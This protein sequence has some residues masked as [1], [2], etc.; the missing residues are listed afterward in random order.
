MYY[1][2]EPIESSFEDKLDRTNFC[3]TFARSIFDLKQ[4]DTFTIGL[5]GKWGAG[6]TSLVNMMLSELKKI[7]EE[8]NSGSIII[9]F[10]PWHFTDSTHLISQFLIK[11]AEEFKDS[12]KEKMKDLFQA[13]IQYASSFDWGS[14]I[15]IPF[16]NTAVSGLQKIAFNYLKKRIERNNA[17]QQDV[18]TQK[19]IVV[20][21]LKKQNK[22][23][24]VIIDDIERLSNE[25]IRQVFQLVASIAKFP[26]TIYLLA[27]DKDI[28]VK[29]LEKFQEGDG[30]DYLEK[31]VQLPLQIPEL[32]NEK[33]YDL[34]LERLDALLKKYPNITIKEER[35]A[36]LFNVCIA[37]FISTIR[38]VNRLINL[39][40]FKFS[41]IPSDVEFSDMVALSSIEINQPIIYDWIKNNKNIVLGEFNYSSY[42]GKKASDERYKEYYD[43]LY[44]LLNP[45][46]EKIESIN[47]LVT[48]TLQRVSVLFPPFGSKIGLY[49]ESINMDEA[50]KYNSVYNE[51]KFDRYFE[52]DLN[53]IG[54]KNAVIDKTVFSSDVLELEATISNANN[55]GF[56]YEIL[57][58][59]KARLDEIN[60]E[61]ASI[62]IQAIMHSIYLISDKDHKK[63][64]SLSSNTIALHLIYTLFNKIDANNRVPLINMLLEDMTIKNAEGMASFINMIELAYGRLAANGIE[65]KEYEKII[66]INDLEAIE[67]RYLDRCSALFQ[68]N[69]IFNAD[70]WR[71]TIYLLKS[72][73]KNYVD[74]LIE[75]ELLSDEN[76]IKFLKSFI[77]EWRGGGIHYEIVSHLEYITEDRVLSAIKNLKEN[78]ALY[79]MNLDDQCR[80]MASYMFF[81]GEY[82]TNQHIAKSETEKELAKWGKE[83]INK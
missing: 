5:Y 4:L 80:A 16:L 48:K 60:S 72:F 9:K 50:R 22:K 58:E 43:K 47:D 18:L 53:K 74:Q 10:N 7:E 21:L 82:N 26:N 66:S 14:F 38:D 23:I 81:T 19:E 77:N 13:L 17:Q 25:Q 49:Y 54:L 63:L 15:P 64:I 44:N 57:K 37:P 2:D 75:K 61:R 31:I 62:I 34:L 33:L 12:K 68:S 56:I 35:W 39:L 42:T 79:A 76:V 70:N 45:T 83:F 27:F 36:K 59:I 40:Q 6:K 29:A 28:V 52:L 30:N 78:G 41:G 20:N 51:D 11:L 46:N 69:S 65:N 73:D 1:S 3:K 32:N 71:M 55:E 24:I 67:K 8:E